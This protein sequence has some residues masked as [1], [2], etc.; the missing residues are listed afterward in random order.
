M[1]NLHQMLVFFYKLIHFRRDPRRLEGGQLL[2]LKGASGGS[3]S[4]TQT[5][6][7]PCFLITVVKQTVTEREARQATS[8]AWGNKTPET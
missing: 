3:P 7:L 1:D 8:D 6:D 5:E 2:L 4:R